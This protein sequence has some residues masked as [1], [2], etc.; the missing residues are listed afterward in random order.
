[1]PLTFD[2][3]L[4]KLKT[5]Q[6][7]N[8]KPADFDMFWD[9]GIA[10]MRAID[11]EVELSPADFQ[12]PFAECLDLYF[13]GVGGAR[14][15]AKLLRPKQAAAPHPAVL[16]F[17]GYSGDSGDW[18]DKLGYVA[19]G[20]TLAA[21]DCRGQGGLSE[22]LGNVVGNTLRGHIIRGLD[23]APEKLL[24]R[25]VYLD[26]AQLARI[27]MDMPGGEP[28]WGFDDRVCCARTPHQ[29]GCT[30]VPV[31]LRLQAGLGD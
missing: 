28:R 29:A 24:F 22:D 11:P 4:E 7:I 21:M 30:G 16:M 14:I 2:L 20:Y 18:T 15:H 27:V 19:M 6:G 25:Q 5:Y 1:M 8:P 12:V 17:H 26:T 13:T 9:R 3:P 10:E 31:P 23:D